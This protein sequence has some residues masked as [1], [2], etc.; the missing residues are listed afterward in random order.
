MDNNNETKN[1]Q[2][3]DSY[4]QEEGEYIINQKPKYKYEIKIIHDGN[5]DNE[6]NRIKSKT[7]NKIYPSSKLNILN[8]PKNNIITKKNTINQEIVSKFFDRTQ[9]SQEI[10]AYLHYLKNLFYQ[11]KR[12][13]FHVL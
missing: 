9:K 5:L 7:P 12:R 11:N 6:K 8:K 13:F 4:F 2:I 10:Y 1:D 3:N